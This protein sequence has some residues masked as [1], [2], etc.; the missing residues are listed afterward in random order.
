MKV[1]TSVTIG[2]SFNDA[3]SQINKAARGQAIRA[4][5]LSAAG[6]LL[7]VVHEEFDSGVGPYGGWIRTLAGNNPLVESG[8]FR[9]SWSAILRGTTAGI[10]SDYKWA[11]VHQF[12]AHIEAKNAWERHAAAVGGV[13]SKAVFKTI[14]VKYDDGLGSSEEKIR[15]RS[16]FKARTGEQ[17]YLQFKVGDQWVRKHSV[18]IPAR[19]VVPND[20]D[21]LP[22]EWMDRLSDAISRCLEDY[23]VAS[24]EP[25]EPEVTAE[26]A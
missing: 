7:R 24:S 25:N 6:E 2:A 12:G 20:G 1:S 21:A 26:A 14:K 5:T 15:V 19:P 3:L 18:D 16:H 13:E 11:M 23:F 22:D 9:S 17:G 10:R 8:E 4:C